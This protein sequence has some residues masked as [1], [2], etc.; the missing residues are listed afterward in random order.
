MRKIGKQYFVRMRV[1]FFIVILLGMTLS[2]RCETVRAKSSIYDS[3]RIIMSASELTMY[4][5]MRAENLWASISY[6]HAQGYSDADYEK[7]TKKISDHLIWT[8]SDPSVVG[9]YDTHDSNGQVKTVG[10]KKG[11]YASL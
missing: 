9:F 1:L 6:S 3:Y 5:G 7:A 2:G 8:S 4:T 11:S 10:K